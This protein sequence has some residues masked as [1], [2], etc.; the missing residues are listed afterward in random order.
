MS[1]PNLAEAPRRVKTAI[2]LAENAK[3]THKLKLFGSSSSCNLLEHQ[4]SLFRSVGVDTICVVGGPKI[5]ACGDE[6][7]QVDRLPPFTDEDSPCVMMDS[8]LYLAHLPKITAS[9]VLCSPIGQ[10]ADIP[11]KL[12]IVSSSVDQAG[13]LYAESVCASDKGSGNASRN[14]PLIGQ[15]TYSGVCFLAGDDLFAYHKLYRKNPAWEHWEILNELAQKTR[16]KVCHS[17]N[18]A[19]TILTTKVPFAVHHAHSPYHGRFADIHY[20][21]PIEDIRRGLKQQR[22]SGR[23]SDN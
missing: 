19:A 20:P 8:R 9:V 4:V 16:L 23:R 3:W 11:D 13:D 21:Q 7:F 2:V 17:P 15:S 5:S 14:S 12:P 6:V 18:L 1:L 22:A 10:Q